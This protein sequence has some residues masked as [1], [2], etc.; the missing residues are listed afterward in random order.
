[1]HPAHDFGEGSIFEVGEARAERAIFVRQ[2]Q[3][4]QSLFP[5]LL[6]EW[7]YARPWLPAIRLGCIPPMPLGLDRIDVLLHEGVE[8]GNEFL[9]LLTLI[10]VHPSSSSSLHYT[11]FAD[12]AERVVAKRVAWARHYPLLDHVTK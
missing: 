9:H 10:D 1:M 4:P 8:L 6:L 11:P 2:E 3:I 12:T 5:G 7:L